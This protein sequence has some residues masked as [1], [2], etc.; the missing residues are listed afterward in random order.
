MIASLQ[1][2]RRCSPVSADA[3]RENRRA[4][5]GFPA[6][7]RALAAAPYLIRRRFAEDRQTLLLGRIA[8]LPDAGAVRLKA[9]FSSGNLRFLAENGRTSSGKFGERESPT[10]KPPQPQQ[11]SLQ[12]AHSVL[13]PSLPVPAGADAGMLGGWP[14]WPSCKAGS[15]PAGKPPAPPVRTA[16][17]QTTTLH[18]P[19][20]PRLQRKRREVGD[21][22]P[23]C[24]LPL[25][26][27]SPEPTPQS[28][29]NGRDG[30]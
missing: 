5:A 12:R 20:P 14:S 7:F 4:R 25:R 8:D 18:F 3:R 19:N 16:R 9:I 28:R 10:A 11:R 22:S 23:N 15:Q 6:R 13:G 24:R 17:V 27:P 2:R 29:E 1:N 26:K 30:W 21:G